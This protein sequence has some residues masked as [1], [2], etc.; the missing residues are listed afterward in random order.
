MRDI[1]TL[2]GR[3]LHSSNW[4]MSPTVEQLDNEQLDNE[5]N[6]WTLQLGCLFHDEHGQEL[7]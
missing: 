3:T 7:L 6:G 5:S 2:D 4:T 1:R